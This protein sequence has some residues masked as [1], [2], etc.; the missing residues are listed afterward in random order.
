MNI[1]KGIRRQL[2][3]TCSSFT[4]SMLELADASDTVGSL[5]RDDDVLLRWAHDLMRSMIKIMRT[6]RNI[7]QHCHPQA[8]GSK[9]LCFSVHSMS[10]ARALTSGVMT[11]KVY[12]LYMSRPVSISLARYLLTK[13]CC[14]G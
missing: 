10:R 12:E 8:A 11:H 7:V 6:L 4:T 1:R 2:R 14:L 5:K 13:S 3:H 9:E